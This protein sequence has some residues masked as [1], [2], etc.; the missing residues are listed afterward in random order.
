MRTK[1]SKSKTR[2]AAG[3]N[4]VTCPY[5]EILEEILGTRDNIVPK[6]VIESNEL[7]KEVRDEV[8]DEAGDEEGDKGDDDGDGDDDEKENEACDDRRMRR[9]R[10]IERA[11]KVRKK[12]KVAKEDPLICIMSESLQLMKAMAEDSRKIQGLFK[13]LIDKFLYPSFVYGS[14][15]SF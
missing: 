11:A 12:K 3:S 5:S 6:Y 14:P 1:K 4:P 7:P 13:A 2:K 9:K 8:R 10:E 15:S